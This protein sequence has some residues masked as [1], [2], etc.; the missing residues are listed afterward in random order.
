MGALR[1][2]WTASTLRSVTRV[3]VALDESPKSLN[4][5][6]TAVRL[7]PDP[8]TEFLVINVATAPVVWTGGTYGDVYGVAPA[9]LFLGPGDHAKE[10]ATHLREEAAAAGMRD[11]RILVASGDAAERIAAAAEEHD[12]DVVVVGSHTK[13]FLRR[14]IDPSVADR[15]VHTAH[16]PVLVVA[17]TDAPRERRPVSADGDEAHGDIEDKL[18]GD[19]LPDS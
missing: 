2:T 16:R 18:S 6:R 7:F 19:E 14:L 12:V 11:P 3:L 10:A 13:N 8:A 15:V 17:T 4:A 5:A 9:I 1:P